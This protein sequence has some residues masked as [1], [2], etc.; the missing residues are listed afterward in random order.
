MSS[1]EE[2]N[3]RRRKFV[4]EYLREPNATKSAKLAGYSS[5]TAYS[6]G[7]HLLK[8]PEI[9]AAVAKA[10]KQYEITKDRILG[11]I[12]R[13]A[14][15]NMQ[16]YTR[17]DADGKP[18]LDLSSITRD[19]FAAVAEITEDTTGGSGD[20]ER[21]LVLRTKLRLHDKTK[22]LELLGKHLKLFIDK[23]EHSADDS[24]AALIAFKL[25]VEGAHGDSDAR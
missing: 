18:V 11:E 5:K 24:L 10:L 1:S 4:A 21:R 25:R 16:D 6:I 8:V 9:M 14:F 20:G 13:S 15:A 22:N 3:T 17:V 12:A 23:V 19:Q 2:V 7:Q